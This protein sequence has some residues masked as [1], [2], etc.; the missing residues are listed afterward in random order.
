VAAV[1][2]ALAGL[3]VGTVL[4]A[5]RS[6]PPVDDF[7]PHQGFSSEVYDR[8]GRLVGRLEGEE[9]RI[10]V[11]L[12]SIPERVQEAF[13][14]VED[15]R[16]WRHRGVDVVALGR[17]LWN[18]L[19]GGSLQGASTITQQLARTA[20][21]IGRERTLRRKL[22][23]ALL[24]LELERRYTKKEILEM[25]LNQIYFGRNLYGIG[26]A[27]EEYFGKKPSQLTLSEAA[28]LAGLP[29]A[30]NAYDPLLRPDSARARRNYVL[31]LMA[32]KGFITPEESA[33]AQEAPLG[34]AEGS[35][36]EKAASPRGWYIDFVLG[37]L[38]GRYSARQVYQGGLKIYTAFDPEIQRAAEEAVEKHLRDLSPEVQAAVV[39]MEQDTG[40]VRAI[41][42]GRR[43][44]TALSLNRAWYD[45]RA[46]CCARQPGS[47]IK[48]IVVYLPALEAGY[49]LASIFDDY[50][51][52][53][54]TPGGTKT[55]RNYDNR[56]HGLTT[57]REAVRR[58]VN[59]VAVQVLNQVG[60]DKGI[61]AA[62]R[63]GITTLV[64]SGPV[65]DRNLSLALGG[66]T[67]GVSP[68]EMARAYAAFANGGFLV[69]PIS[70][71]KVEDSRGVVLE[72]HRPVKRRV[73]RPEVAYLMVDLLRSAVE[74]QPPG[75]WNENVSL[76]ARARV[77][78]WPTAGKT[79]T[80]T[81]NRDV[82]FVGFTPR[83]TAAVWVGIDNP[84][85]DEALPRSVM[86]GRQPAYIFK[87]L[88]E[89][90]L[91]GQKP[92]SFPQ[93]PGLTWIWISAKSGKRAGENTPKEW[94]RKELF[95]A[96]T[97]PK[98]YD[99]AFVAA[100][101][102]AEKPDRLYDPACDC[103]PET[104]LFL[105]RPPPQISDPKYLPLDLA[106][107]PPKE[108]CLGVSSSVYGSREPEASFPVTPVTFYPDR[109]EPAEI[110]LPVGRTQEL[111]LRTGDVAHHLE[112]PELGLRVD[113]PPEQAVR[114]KLELPR[115]G[116]YVLRCLDHE[117]EVVRI[118]GEGP[119]GH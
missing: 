51:V 96:G 62:Q 61:E 27:A 42:G 79:G 4:A 37:Q 40:Y 71:L 6:L 13:V 102:C 107:T 111:L 117:G 1:S 99:D 2:V 48:P 88:M 22:Q 23:E 55:F 78:G 30:P 91:Q 76:G 109:V 100:T 68:L 31:K 32:Q 70:I 26:A 18:D 39:V 84:R 64:L 77:S 17:A 38:L 57:I 29:Q 101:V 69:E 12:E 8:H 85:K 106:L 114:V 34:V 36:R 28:L 45:P 44:Q 112:I 83:L 90:A 52:S 41:V 43:H 118:R 87:D 24:A 93:P 54:R 16:F 94:V 9:N 47:A 53:F 81:G 5:W 97:E 82:W 75:G 63:L 113:L 105:S 19:R 59:T 103:T 20:F 49:T 3:A 98:S 65:N 56:Y 86:S 25:Y 110:S 115:E 89:R 60:V 119:P 108:S 104:K 46:G 50:P 33:R 21:P 35:R 80:T 92:S 58:S 14:A 10:F 74:P 11:P 116:I 73:I 95:L 67:R 7:S 66:L 15:E 72:E